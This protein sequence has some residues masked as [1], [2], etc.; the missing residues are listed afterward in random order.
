MCIKNHMKGRLSPGSK[1]SWGAESQESQLDLQASWHQGKVVGVPR[2]A[3]LRHLPATLCPC[4][5][6]LIT[7]IQH[8]TPRVFLRHHQHCPHLRFKARAPT[9]KLFSHFTLYLTAS[10]R[11]TLPT[12]FFLQHTDASLITLWQALA[13]PTPSGNV[14]VC[15][16]LFM[17]THSDDPHYYHSWW[18]SS[19]QNGFGY[20][21]FNLDTF[22]SQFFSTLTGHL[23]QA[24]NTI[25]R[26]ITTLHLSSVSILT[27]G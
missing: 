26:Y 22:F 10:K 16:E 12:F 27:K 19:T 24:Y 17:A 2:T 21:W 20:F 18:H 8:H 11:N 25:H 23:Y 4:V 15:V 9:G 6:G 14:C 3:L 7:P 5:P 1:K 13:P